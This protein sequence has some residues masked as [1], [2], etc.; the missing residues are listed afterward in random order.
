MRLLRGQDGSAAGGARLEAL[1]GADNMPA[2]QTVGRWSEE[3]MKRG[4][5]IADAG[6]GRGSGGRVG[7]EFEG[8]D[9]R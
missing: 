8:S 2:G 7:C 9:G 4:I 5:A 3:R 1:V 6:L